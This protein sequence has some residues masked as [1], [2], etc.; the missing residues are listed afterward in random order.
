MS[1]T[2]TGEPRTGWRDALGE[3]DG[4][5]VLVTGASGGIGAAVADAFAECGANVCLH[6]GRNAPKASATVA[7]LQRRGL[8]ASTVGADLSVEGAAR[9]MVSEAVALL[10]GL[11]LL[12]NVAG[13]P[14]SR[15]TIDVLDDRQCTAVL[16]LNLRAVVDAIQAAVPHLRRGTNAAIINTSSVAVRSGGGR[17]VAVYAAAKSGVESLTRSLA[18][19]LAGDGIRVNCVAPG[20]IETPIHEG[21]SSDDDRRAYVAATPMARGGAADECVGAYLFLASHRLSSFVTGQTVAVNGGLAL[22]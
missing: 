6:H 3:F 20:Y 22:G 2:S 11:D 7:A 21:F 15:A 8:R 4:R 18:R 9:A 19:E 12:V 17:G 5:R 16:Q 10:G 14:L 1:A 13:S